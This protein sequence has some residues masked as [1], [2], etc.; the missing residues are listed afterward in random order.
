MSITTELF[1]FALCFLVL[2]PFPL[3]SFFLSFLL[4]FLFVIVASLSLFLHVYTIKSNIGFL[5]LHI[6][7]CVVCPVNIPQII[8]DSFIAA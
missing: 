8:I 4:L 1:D 7:L 5:V 2:A 6:W 3:F